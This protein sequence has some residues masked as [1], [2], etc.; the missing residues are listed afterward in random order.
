VA[1]YGEVR[2]SVT[3]SENADLSPAYLRGPAITRTYAPVNTISRRL[4][5]ATTPGN[6]IDTTSFTTVTMVVV[7]NRDTTN[8]VTAT[9]RSAANGA[10][11]NKVKIPAGGVF[12]TEDLTK[13]NGI[14]FV[15]DTATCSL[16]VWVF[17][18]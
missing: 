16:D 6:S 17:G 14:T 11:D 12:A 1:D 5:I 9:W 7:H 4:T 8:F 2:I 3:A 18:T 10:T 15:A 13:A